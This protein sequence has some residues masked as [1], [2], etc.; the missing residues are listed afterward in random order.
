MNLCLI[1]FVHVSR[2]ASW[3]PVCAAIPNAALNFDEQAFLNKR[4]VPTKLPPRYR[5]VLSDV[6]SQAGG[7]E[8]EGEGVFKGDVIRY[9][10]SGFCAR[11][12]S[13]P[14]LSS[15]SLYLGDWYAPPCDLLHRECQAS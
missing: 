11:N 2:N 7:V 15:S 9:T 4:E 12:T 1:K 14:G 6:A 10:P 8:L 13:R 3:S 5:G